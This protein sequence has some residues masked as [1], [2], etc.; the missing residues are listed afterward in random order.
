MS[1]AASPKPLSIGALEAG[2]P[3][4]RKVMRLLF[5]DGKTLEQIQPSLCWDRLRSPHHC[6]PRS[7]RD[8]E[9]MYFLHREIC[10]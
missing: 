9:L 1:Q 7:D 2:Y 5:R 10:A 8:P 6:L 3:L 4:Y